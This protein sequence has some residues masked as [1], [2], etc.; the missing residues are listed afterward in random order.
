VD[1]KAVMGVVYAP[2]TDELYLAVKGHGAY[3]NGVRITSK[4]TPKALVDSVVCVEF[5]YSRDKK[6][7][8]LMVGAVQRIL[9]NGC[10]TMRIIGS[11]VLDLCYVATGRLDVVYAGVAGEG[12]KPCTFKDQSHASFLCG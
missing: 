7:I 1:R 12:W 4:R 8:G 10:R 11:G 3:R 6:S 2:M 5:G 9:E